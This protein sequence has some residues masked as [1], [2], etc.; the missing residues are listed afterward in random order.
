MMREWHTCTSDDETKTEQKDEEW[1]G[2]KAHWFRENG[3]WDEMCKDDSI[4]KGCPC[5]C[6]RMGKWEGMKKNHPH[7]DWGNWGMHGKGGMHG[8]KGE[9]KGV[10]ADGCYDKGEFG[11]WCQ[12][13]DGEWYE[14]STGKVASKSKHHTGMMWKHTDAT[15]TKLASSSS[16][17]SVNQSEG[18]SSSGGGANH[19][20]MGVMGG[21]S[22]CLL[23]LAAAL[24]VYQRR[25]SLGLQARLDYEM[26]D[27]RN[28]ATPGVGANVVGMQQAQADKAARSAP[29]DLSGGA[30]E[31]GN[32][33]QSVDLASI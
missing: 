28:L 11:V 14:K 19:A 4:V 18:N 32:P 33:L 22:G 5:M 31:V 25:R 27:A 13:A 9:G 17:S 1:C 12:K 8:K 23:L 29:L 26:N 2:D 30:V 6:Q 3:K 10:D 21:S 7:H 16:S 24:V 20:M 15:A